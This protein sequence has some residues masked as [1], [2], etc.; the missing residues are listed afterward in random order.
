ME[1]RL[2][3]FLDSAIVNLCFAAGMQFTLWIF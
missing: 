3:A 2:L 1:M